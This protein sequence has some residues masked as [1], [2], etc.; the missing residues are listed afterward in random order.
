M[1]FLTSS[2]FHSVWHHDQRSGA[3]RE[4]CDGSQPRVF[5]LY[6]ALWRLLRCTYHHWWP[7]CTIYLC[8]HEAMSHRPKNKHGRKHI[9]YP[10]NTESMPAWLSWIKY[11]SFLYYAFSGL[12]VNEFRDECCWACDKEC[13]SFSDN[14][15]CIK[16]G[17]MQFLHTHRSGACTSTATTQDLTMLVDACELATKSWTGGGLATGPYGHPM[18]VLL[19]RIEPPLLFP[20]AYVDHLSWSLLLLLRSVCAV[21]RTTHH[22]SQKHRQH[23]SHALSWLLLPPCAQVALHAT[24]AAQCQAGI[25][26]EQQCISIRSTFVWIRTTLHVGPF[27]CLFTARS[28]HD[29]MLVFDAD[30]QP[31]AWAVVG[32][33]Q[34]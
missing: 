34:F 16:R 22:L 15:V 14:G 4:D 31:I 19:V 23:S 5:G 33:H 13:L 7:K 21:C 17:T 20:D 11:I 29:K 32:P 28:R 18:S 26:S 10:Q 8:M 27:M 6:D 12:A 9:D 3:Q 2:V 30:C 24:A 25:V 1:S